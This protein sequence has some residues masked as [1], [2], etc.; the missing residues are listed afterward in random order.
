MPLIFALALAAAAPTASQPPG[1]A[2]KLLKDCSAHRFETTINL[3]VDGKPRQSKVKMCGIPGQ[4]D[5]QWIVTLKDA[6]AKVEANLTMP[7]GVKSQIVNAVNAEILRVTSGMGSAAPSTA[8]INAPALPVPRKSP[9]TSVPQYSPL[10]PFPPPPPAEKAIALGAAGRA[11][12]AV[13]YV[14]PLPRP[15]LSFTCF[16]PGDLATDAPCLTIDRDTIISVRAGEPLKDTLLRFV[17][18]GDE[19]ADVALPPLGRGRAAR[20]ALPREVCAHVVGGSLSIR[21]VRGPAGKPDFA[22]VVGTEGPYILRC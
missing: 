7:A 3:V 15:R 13:P 4:T 2:Q 6:V 5:A 22:Q 10:P 9:A 14:A 21:I 20:I 18:D 11:S 8:L 16:N 19:R 1:D 17:R 12:A